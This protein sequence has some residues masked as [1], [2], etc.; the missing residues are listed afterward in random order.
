[1]QPNSVGCKLCKERM[2][3]DIWPRWTLS[4]KK[5]FANFGSEGAMRMDSESGGKSG[6]N[7]AQHQQLSETAKSDRERERE[8][9]KNKK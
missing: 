3:E 6:E 2:Q 9:E 1:M 4:S 5:V 7:V 8:R